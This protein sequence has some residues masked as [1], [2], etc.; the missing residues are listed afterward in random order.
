MALLEFAQTARQGRCAFQCEIKGASDILVHCDAEIPRVLRGREAG[1]RLCSILMDE[2]SNLVTDLMGTGEQAENGTRIDK[3]LRV[4]DH[5]SSGPIGSKQYVLRGACVVDQFIGQ[6]EHDIAVL[7][8]AADGVRKVVG[9]R[10]VDRPQAQVLTACIV[11]QSGLVL[12]R[13]GAEQD[14]DPGGGRKRE[15]DE[16][17]L[18]AN[19]LIDEN[20]G[21]WVGIVF[22]V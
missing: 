13:G 16:S 19:R 22:G 17:K 4:R 18:T 20:R 15:F 1:L 9:T 2:V 6:C 11:Q 8:Q 3:G 21:M 14:A 5:R 10:H 12:R 7:G